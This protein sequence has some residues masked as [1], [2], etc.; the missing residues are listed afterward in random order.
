MR[1]FFGPI[2]FAN[3]LAKLDASWGQIDVGTY[4]A[5]LINRSGARRILDF[6]VNQRQITKTSP[7]GTGVPGLKRVV[8]DIVLKHWSVFQRAVTF[9][10]LGTGA[11]LILGLATR[12][13]ARSLATR[14]NQSS[15]PC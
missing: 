10:E 12:L 7:H 9:T 2:V 3:G 4:H 11:L 15:A 5:N 6:E 8:N 13:G 14:W 1:I